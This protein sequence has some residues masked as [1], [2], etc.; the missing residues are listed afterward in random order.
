[1]L[2]RRCDLQQRDIPFSYKSSLTATKVA[3]GIFS[4]HYRCVWRDRGRGQNVREQIA[5]VHALVFSPCGTRQAGATNPSTYIDGGQ[6]HPIISMSR[7]WRRS[8]T[9]KLSQVLARRHNAEPEIRTR[10]RAVLRMSD[11]FNRDLSGRQIAARTLFSVAI[12]AFI[13]IGAYFAIAWL[14]TLRP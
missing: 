10:D 9:P 1:V 13:G 14:A 12:T 2:R 11:H 8:N 6:Y 5:W 3:T 4:C 7:C